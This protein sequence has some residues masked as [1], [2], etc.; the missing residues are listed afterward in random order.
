MSVWYSSPWFI[1]SN[2]G[3]SALFLSSKFSISFELLSYLKVSM[4]CTFVSTYEL[5]LITFA[6]CKK[7]PRFSLY[8]VCCLKFYEMVTLSYLFARGRSIGNY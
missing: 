8:V 6:V 2:G 7:Y 5:L 3:M 4:I 1:C